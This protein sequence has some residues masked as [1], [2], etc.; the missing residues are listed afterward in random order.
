M[1]RDLQYWGI[2]SL[3]EMVSLKVLEGGWSMILVRI[4]CGGYWEACNLGGLRGVLCRGMDFF[5]P[6]GL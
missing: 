6:F 2:C 3:L 5:N 4:C 1:Y